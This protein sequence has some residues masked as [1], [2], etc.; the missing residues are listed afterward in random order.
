M[1]DVF[2]SLQKLKLKILSLQK[3]IEQLRAEIK[4]KSG[5]ISELEEKLK[6]QVMKIIQLSQK[7][8]LEWRKVSLK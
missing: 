1:R 4:E 8:T 3:L 7:G 2:I 6:T 5:T